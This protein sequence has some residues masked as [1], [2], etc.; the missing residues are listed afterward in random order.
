MGND[1]KFLK[2]IVLVVLLIL[3]L[4]L[5]SINNE[6]IIGDE[7]WNFQNIMKM[8]NGGKIYVDNN[9]IITP[10]F[11]FL[12]I[13]LIKLLGSNILGFRIYN[14]IIFCFL[15][16]SIFYIFKLLKIDN[17]KCSLYTLLIFLF[18]M[19]YIPVGANYNVLAVSLYLARDN[20]IFK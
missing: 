8:I 16:L 19:P 13:P 9:V 18:V 15:L 14:V 11:Y 10:I 17:L 5:I 20:Y 3:P 12:G 1:K 2:I 7:I 6:L 4:A